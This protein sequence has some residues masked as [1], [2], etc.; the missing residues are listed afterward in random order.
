MNDLAILTSA[1]V[2]ATAAL[3]GIPASAAEPNTPVVPE[4]GDTVSIGRATIEVTSGRIYAESRPGL[5]QVSR[6][7]IFDRG[8]HLIGSRTLLCWVVVSIRSEC[9]GTFQFPRGNIIVGGVRSSR[10]SYVLAVLGGTGL[11]DNARGSL[12]INQIGDDPKRDRVFIQLV[13]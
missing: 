3:F 1:V 6:S 4:V 13:G 7:Q 10:R 5:L 9:R 11:Y 2:L 12:S 8:G